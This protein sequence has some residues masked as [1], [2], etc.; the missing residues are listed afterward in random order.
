[1][2]Y[3]NN[4]F[5]K[6]DTFANDVF[7]PAH[8]AGIGLDETEDCVNKK[9]C[10]EIESCEKFIT[11]DFYVSV[12]VCIKPYVACECP[13]VEC[14]GHVE[15]KCGHEHCKGKGKPFKYT[16]KQKLCVKVPI[17]CGCE[18][19]YDTACIEEA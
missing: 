12:P 3:D 2:V 5:T 13:E 15:V 14:V 16:V 18:T 6:E 11:K 10:Y 1:M 4:D 9:E 7:V 8:T 19:C 17:K